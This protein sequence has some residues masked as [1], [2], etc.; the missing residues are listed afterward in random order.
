MWVNMHV[1]TYKNVIL[2]GNVCAIL[3]ALHMHTYFQA[4]MQ[5]K[6][7]ITTNISVVC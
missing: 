1:W 3:Y 7:F 4:F 6:M 2:S 5:D